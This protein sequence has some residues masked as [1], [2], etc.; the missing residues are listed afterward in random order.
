MG[1]AYRKDD[2]DDDDDDDAC[3]LS[4]TVAAAAAD[5]E[6]N[7]L[8]RLLNISVDWNFFPADRNILNANAVYLPVQK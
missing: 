7:C 2:D 4:D 6:E 5:E 8:L 3:S 1:T